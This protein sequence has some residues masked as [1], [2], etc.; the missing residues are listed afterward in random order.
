[1]DD[2]MLKQTIPYKDEHLT[3]Q[4]HVEDVSVLIAL[5]NAT[6]VTYLNKSLESKMIKDEGG[7]QLFTTRAKLCQAF[8]DKFH[9]FV[10][11]GEPKSR[12]VH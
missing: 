6:K 3:V 5:L 7:E 10:M 2:E 1:M 11:V 4:L 8:S 9:E 12:D